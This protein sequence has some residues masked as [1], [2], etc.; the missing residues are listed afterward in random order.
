MDRREFI[1]LGGLGALASAGL[2]V[3][4]TT[5]S[6]KSASLLSDA[7]FPKRYAY[8]FRRPPVLKPYKAATTDTY[9]RTVQHYCVTAR[10]T[11]ATILERLTTPVYAYNGSCPARRPGRAGERGQAA[12]PQP[13]PGAA[14]D[15]R[16]RFNTSTHLH[17]SA[18]LPQFDGYAERRHPP[19]G[20][21]GLLVP[22]LA[23]GADALVPRPQRH[24]DGAERLLRPG[25]AVPPAR[26][27][28]ARPAP[29]GATT[30]S[31]SPSP[32]RCS[33]PTARSPTTT[34]ATRG[35]GATSSSS[36]AGP[37]R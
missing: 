18:S 25:R 4:L 16:R 15:V 12:G 27:G 9:G 11:T 3:P 36:T 19:R 10:P 28:G 8:P 21:Q 22:E 23:A 7:D 24:D 29:A 35:C 13:P 34:T 37:G 30:T 14:P 20:L 1:K 33:P 32:T 26:R 17:G 31:R 5:V 6:A 2:V